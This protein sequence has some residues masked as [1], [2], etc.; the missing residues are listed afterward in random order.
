MPRRLLIADDDRTPPAETQ[1]PVS[2]V[3]R[4]PGP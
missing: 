2:R 1:A 3:A 4:Q